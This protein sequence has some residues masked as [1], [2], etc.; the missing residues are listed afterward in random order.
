M[1][2]TL[3]TDALPL[4]HWCSPR[5]SN[6]QLLIMFCGVEDKKSHNS[7]V[8]S[9]AMFSQSDCCSFQLL[10]V[11]ACVALFPLL[12]PDQLVGLVVRHPPRDRHT[13]L[14][15]S[16]SPGIFFQV[17]PYLWLENWHC[18]IYPA[19]FLVWQG[20]CWNWLAWCQCTVTGWWD[21]N[22]D[23]NFLSLCGST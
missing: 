12:V 8:F 11:I 23:V 22:F 1:P 17:K 2:S 10:F 5:D 7:L 20:Q 13:W 21:K 19:R 3:K 6:S 4:G 14:W 15:F 18:R 16:L 9:Q